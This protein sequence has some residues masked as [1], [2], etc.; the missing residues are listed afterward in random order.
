VIH[1]V[2]GIGYV[3]GDR[4][5]RP[6]VWGPMLAAGAV[7]LLVTI[8]A[9]FWL[10]PWAQDWIG[11]IPILGYVSGLLGVLAFLIFWWLVSSML[12]LGIAGILS[13]FLWEKLSREIERMEGT[14]PDPEAKVG[15]GGIFFDTAIRTGI[16]LVIAFASLLLGWCLFGAVGI[17][18]AGWLGL[19]DFTSC[20]Y[21]RRGMLIDRQLAVVYQCPGW[22]S[23][24][25]AAG[26]LSMFPVVNVIMLPAL[27]AGGTL[28]CAKRYGA[29]VVARGSF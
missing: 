8:L 27:V 22:G 12:Y 29:S 23:F 21:A 9:Y 5:L 15:C 6:Y 20:A 26:V 1:L 28:L 17:L 13:A 2:R 3:F 16:T 7:Y 19:L 25:L 4:R 14:L 18:L 24:L 11:R 10:A